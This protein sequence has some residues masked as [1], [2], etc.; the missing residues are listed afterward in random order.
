LAQVERLLR[1]LAAQLQ[2]CEVSPNNGER[3]HSGVQPH[4]LQ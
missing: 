2:H 4:G 1:K 3:L